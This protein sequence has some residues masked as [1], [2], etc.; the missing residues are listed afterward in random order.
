[1]SRVIYLLE[2]ASARID[3]VI[4]TFYSA[5]SAV[6]FSESMI[7]NVAGWL[8]LVGACSVGVRVAHKQVP[9][10]R[11]TLRKPR[12]SWSFTIGVS[13]LSPRTAFIVCVLQFLAV[14]DE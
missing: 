14:E 2:M 11:N 9:K 4:G 7:S 13:S 5:S 3:K 6:R 12:I 8:F 1:M 10:R